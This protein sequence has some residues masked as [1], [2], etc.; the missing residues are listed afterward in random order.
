MILDTQTRFSDAQAVTATAISENVLDLR[1]AATP[2][3]V[4]EGIVGDDLWLVIK[5]TEAFTAAGAATLTVS[6]ESDSTADLA[7]S[8]TVHYSTSAIALANLGANTVIA[9]VKLPSGNY[10]R[11]LGVRYTVATGPMTA[12]SVEA[13]L[14]PNIDRSVNY[15]SGFSV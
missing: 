10:E 9:R 15:P 13:F 7:T 1:N 12:G 11:Y 14:T 5:T 4:D 6:L 2:A 8:A 3:T